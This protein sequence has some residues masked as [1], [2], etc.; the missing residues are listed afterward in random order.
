MQH[1]S[2]ILRRVHVGRMIAMICMAGPDGIRNIEIQRAPGIG[3]TTVQHWV[4]TLRQEYG[5]PI[6]FSDKGYHWRPR[7]DQRKRAQALIDVFCDPIPEKP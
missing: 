4:V 6:T 1:K 2:N 7:P 5:A 3:R